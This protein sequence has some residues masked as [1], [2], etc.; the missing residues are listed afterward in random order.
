MLSFTPSQKIE[1]RLKILQGLLAETYKDLEALSP[2]ETKYIHRCAFISNIGASTRIENAVLTDQ[3]IE[4]I[5]TTL[6]EHGKATAFE[7]KKSF[8]LDKLSKDRERSVEEVVGCRQML[9]TVY[10]QADELFPLSEVTVRGLHHDLLRYYPKASSYAGGYKTAPNRVVSI[11]HETGE[12]RVVLEPSPPGIITATAMAELINWYNTAIQDYPW[13]ILVATEFIFR[14]LAIHPFQDGNGRLGRALFI[15]AL[16]HS[17]D[18]YL[19]SITP[20][21]AIDRHIEQN[22]ILYYS[23]LHQCSEGRFKADYTQ[24]KLEP[25]AWFFINILE[26]SLADIEIYRKRYNNLQKLSESASTV[27]NCFRSSPEKRLKVGDIVEKTGL[28]RRTVQYT[29]KTLTKQELLQMLGRGAG[30][31]YQLVF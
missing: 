25:L 21:I 22:H 8:I 4:W 31:R 30:S 24:Y 14:F 23:I 17:G 26:S 13:P 29:L 28:P 20:Y 3:E 9:A 10:L 19:T 12:E 11:N 5:D 18:K 15:L 1:N 16:F 2:D 6:N 27:L 7:E